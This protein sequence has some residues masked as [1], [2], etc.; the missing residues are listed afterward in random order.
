MT[1]TCIQH[2]SF[3][4]Y[5][6]DSLE[7]LC[8]KCGMTLRETAYLICGSGN[9]PPLDSDIESF[10]KW[11]SFGIKPDMTPGIQALSSG[12]AQI[13][14]H[15]ELCSNYVRRMAWEGHNSHGGFAWEGTDYWD[16]Y[17]KWFT[18]ILL[19]WHY[20]YNGSDND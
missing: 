1:N 7:K 16:Q 13:E 8:A 15:G 6:F 9:I 14:S 2:N 11:Q 3:D 10:R 20:R 18:K 4:L 19:F 5:R 17:P 12:K